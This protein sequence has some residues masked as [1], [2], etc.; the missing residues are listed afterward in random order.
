MTVYCAC[1]HSETMTFSAHGNEMETGALE[2]QLGRTQN[3]VDVCVNG[4]CFYFSKC[5]L[6]IYNT[7]PKLMGEHGKKYAV[8]EN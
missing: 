2:C 4:R 7:C 8:K 6:Y 1:C 5:N 3:Y